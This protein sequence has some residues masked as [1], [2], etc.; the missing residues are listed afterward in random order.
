MTGTPTP[1]PCRVVVL[2][3]GNGSNL[4]AIVDSARLAPGVELV[5]AISNRPEAG[6]LLRAKAAGIQTAVLDHREYTGREDFD[7]ALAKQIDTYRP[8]LLVLAGFM[9]IFTAAF[10]LHYEGRMLNI[11]PSLLP[12]HR[13]L[14]THQS[15]LD[16]GDLEHGATV[17]FVTAE[18]D[19]GPPVLQA[20]VPVE[21]DDTAESLARRVLAREH[22]IYPLAIRWFCEGRIQWRDQTAW[23][24]GAPLRKPILIP[25]RCREHL[26]HRPG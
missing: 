15:A 21:P 18:L 19:G 16:A 25:P 23:F 2:L 10:V 4:Q 11:H 24:D 20:T 5:A 14:K 7:L 13:G 1:A 26:R 3:S 9:R 22:Q 8:D 12:R 6:G 17:H